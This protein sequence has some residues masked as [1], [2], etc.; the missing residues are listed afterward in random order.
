M[1]HALIVIDMQNDFCP[2]GALAV[3]NGDTI[4]AGIN[5]QMAQAD[6]VVL[7][8]DWHPAGH[9]S[10]ASMHEGCAPMDSVDMPYGTQVL[11]PDH[12]VQGSHGADFHP[13]LDTTRADLILRKG[14]RPDIDSYSAFFEN[15]Q[16][17]PTG[18]EGYLRT[19]GITELDFVGL[20]MDFCVAWSARDAARL[21]FNTRVLTA[22]CRG[23]DIDGSVARAQAD[24]RAAGVELV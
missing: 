5:A 18:L 12:C 11:W 1:T 13:E 22:L 10:F 2:G 9:S 14:F 7:T 17:T 3:A 16:T 24:L 6:A 19:R 20:A 23:I 21:G 8:Q 15:D 4:V